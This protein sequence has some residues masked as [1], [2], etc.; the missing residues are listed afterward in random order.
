MVLLRG[1]LP[2]A[3]SSMPHDKPVI[4]NIIASEDIVSDD[5]QGE[6]KW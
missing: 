2:G 5:P 3:V 1:Y 4:E 6:A